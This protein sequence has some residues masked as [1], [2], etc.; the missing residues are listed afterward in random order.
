VRCFQSQQIIKLIFNGGLAKTFRLMQTHQVLHLRVAHCRPL[1]WGD[2]VPKSCD[3]LDPSTDKRFDTISARVSANEAEFVYLDKSMDL[4]SG[5]GSLEF[6]NS[7]YVRPNRPHAVLPL[8]SLIEQIH[9]VTVAGIPV[10]LT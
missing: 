4:V 5:E 10:Y 8:T 1:S 3:V 9:S 2:D 7:W 6:Y